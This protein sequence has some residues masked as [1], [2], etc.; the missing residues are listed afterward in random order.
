[1]GEVKIE[2]KEQRNDQIPGRDGL[3]LLSFE[4]EVPGQSST[5]ENSLET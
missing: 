2:L 4:L 5:W 1:M 3:W